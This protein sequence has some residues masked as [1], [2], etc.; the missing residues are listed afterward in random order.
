MSEKLNRNMKTAGVSAINTAPSTMR[1]RSRAPRALLLWSGIELEDV[2][3]QQ[4]Q[5]HQ[6]QQEHQHRE[7]G[8]DQRLPGGLGIEKPYVGS[9]ECLQRAQ[10]DEKQ[11]HPAA[12]QG[13]R[14]PPGSPRNGMGRL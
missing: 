10:Q 11:Q 5:Q 14:P 6:Q 8:K 1:V 3:E 7:A 13:N 9:V 12:E 2:P 4:H